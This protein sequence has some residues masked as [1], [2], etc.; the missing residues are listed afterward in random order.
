MYLVIGGP[1][2]SGKGTQGQKLASK[3]RLPYF[4]TGAALRS[5]PDIR[6]K[7]L[8]EDG[9]L[10]PNYVTI[11]LVRN[12]L[13]ENPGGWIIDG[14]PRNLYQAGAMSTMIECP[15]F[16]IISLCASEAVLLERLVARKRSD[17]QDD[18]IQ[19]RI[20]IFFGETLSGI[21]ELGNDPRSV[22]KEV[23]AE[24]SIDEV[25]DTI[26]NKLRI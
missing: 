2:G 9:K 18:A 12:F 6:I 13:Q 7:R 22:V 25:H 3:L 14:F 19:Q 10:A 4:E 16:Y 26:C 23:N 21:R 20:R 17:D 8:L 24:L 5:I 11:G 1:A 15:E